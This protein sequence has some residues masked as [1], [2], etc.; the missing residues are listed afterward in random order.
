MTAHPL[1]EP[2]LTGR[3]PTLTVVICCYTMARW[4]DLVA[5]VRSVQHQQHPAEELL[6]VVDHCPELAVRAA[7]VLA[8]VTVVPNRERPGLSGARN[9]GT[10]LAH[11]EVV[12]FLDD[13]ATADPDWTVCLL[14]GYRDRRVLGV[15]GL[16]RPRWE[17]GRPAW[18]PPEFDWVVGCSY[19]GMP[20]RGG[21]VRNFIG[22]NMSFRRAELLA[23]GGFRPDLGR[24]GSRP[25]G[26]EE[27]E[28]CIRLSARHP[29]ALL[30]YEP[31]AGVSHRVPEGRTNW[32]YFQARCYAEGLSK[33]AVAR[34]A[35]RRP[36]LASERRYLRS[37]VPRGMARALRPGG[38]GPRELGALALGV[39]VTV[40]GYA[41]GRLRQLI[42]PVGPV[43]P[44]GAP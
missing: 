22:A 30:R 29:D 17:S 38:G 19:L 3:P 44:G 31:S 2:V 27:T 12:A 34:H 32:T 7:G 23:A 14:A 36:A 13:D 26:C 33:A 10:A 16:V 35:G 5:A 1:T 15:G 18:F 8:D 43:G 6:L 11:G 21:C 9:T 37:T 28:L 24:V 42:G 4:P 25:L 39:A 40:G 20:E 41:T